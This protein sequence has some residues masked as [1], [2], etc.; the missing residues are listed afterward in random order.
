VASIADGTQ[1]A[2]PAAPLIDCGVATSSRPSI[3]VLASGRGSNFEALARASERNELGGTLVLLA[4]DQPDAPALERARRLNIDAIVL[5]A[6]RFRTR[7]E[8]ERPWIEAL[9]ARDVSVVLLAGFMRRLHRDFLSAFERRILNIHPSLLPSFP[10]LAAITQ[11]WEHGVRVSGCTVHLVD[12]ELDHGP[13]VAQAAVEIRDD[14]TLE[15]FETRI[16]E[17][18]HRLYPMAVSR[19][20]TEPWRIEG[21][22][23]AFGAGEKV[24]GV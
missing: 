24:A 1:F 8:D 7:L 6:G 16:H 11:A 19:F 21:R 17:A 13:V 5:P 2:R 4:V 14:D 12:A 20:L 15:S 22:R 18:E 3:A 10:G 9:K 23:L